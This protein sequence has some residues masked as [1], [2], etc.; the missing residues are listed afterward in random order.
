MTSSD[1]FEPALAPSGAAGAPPLVIATHG[2]AFVA[3]ADTSLRLPTVDELA[4]HLDGP[5][6]FVGSLGPTP[7]FSAPLR[8]PSAAAAPFELPAPLALVSA[9][10]ALFAFDQPLVDA[11][12]QAI[13][14]GEWEL[15]SRHCGRC[16]TRTEP[17]TGERARRCPACETSFRPRVPPAVIVLVER[18]GE[19]LLARS[20][21]FP[22]GMFGLIAGFVEPG[23]SLEQAAIRE[24]REE[25][26]IEVRDLAYAGSQ[27]WP[28]GRSLMIGFRATYAAGALVADGKEIEAAGFFSRDRLP[29]LPPPASIARRLIDAWVAGGR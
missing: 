20:P 19:I 15:T 12:G 25:V 18:A 2:L 17:V 16:A 22:A 4:P 26:G 27:P 29:T 1:G 13:A 5:R 23:E 8:C 14:I 24:L 21:G 11:V 3:K 28:I 9:R 7:V 6:I 10:R